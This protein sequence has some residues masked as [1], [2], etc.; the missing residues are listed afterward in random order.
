MAPSGIEL[1]GEEG[2]AALVNAARHR[3]LLEENRRREGIA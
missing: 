2:L 3:V 1:R